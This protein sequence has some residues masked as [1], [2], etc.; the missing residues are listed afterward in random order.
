VGWFL[1]LPGVL[2]TAFG[3]AVLA[4]RNRKLDVSEQI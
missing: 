2:I 1:I 4:W 3:A